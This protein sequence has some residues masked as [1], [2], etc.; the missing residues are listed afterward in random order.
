MSFPPRRKGLIPKALP[1][2]T[3]QGPA[4]TFPHDLPGVLALQ[5]AAVGGDL[6][7]QPRLDV[8]QH[9]VLLVLAL[10]LIAELAQLGL[11]VADEALDVLQ[12]HGVA[13][14]GLRRRA[15]QPG[16][17]VGQQRRRS[18]GSRA[19]GRGLEGAATGQGQQVYHAQL[20]LQLNLQ[21]LERMPELRDLRLAGLDNGGAGRHLLGQLCTLEFKQDQGDG[22]AQLEG[23]STPWLSEVRGPGTLPRNHSSA[24]RRFFS[25]M[26]SYCSLISVSTRVRSMPGVAS[27]STLTWPTTWFLN[28]FISCRDGKGRCMKLLSL[29]LLGSECYWNVLESA[30]RSHGGGLSLAVAE[31][32]PSSLKVIQPW[33]AQPTSHLLVVLLHVGQLLDQVLNLHLQVGLQQGQFVHHPAQA[34][35]VGLHA[36]AQ[37]Q[38]VL[39][40]KEFLN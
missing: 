14:L 10:H 32:S 16:F 40:P 9:L 31:G 27:I 34:V 33:Q 2:L 17:L 1:A 30:S 26:A 6:L 36:L 23:P 25:A 28:S 13:A 38:L 39:I 5:Q 20:G 4:V 3:A 29:P 12:L 22:R 35:G 15:L 24:S 21:T 8:Q 11:D 19:R 18:E 37:G 7:L